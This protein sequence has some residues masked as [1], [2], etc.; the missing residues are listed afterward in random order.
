MAF[1]LAGQQCRAVVAGPPKNEPQSVKDM[2]KLLGVLT[3]NCSIDGMRKVLSDFGVGFDV[4]NTGDGGTLFVLDANR[5][6]SFNG[7]TVFN[8]R[9][10][11]KLCRLLRLAP[12]PRLVAPF[13][14]AHA[15]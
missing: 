11:H 15:K 7:G 8:V 3:K 2:R 6:L 5:F 1:D 9:R 12:A 13:Y 10:G 14:C 4:Q